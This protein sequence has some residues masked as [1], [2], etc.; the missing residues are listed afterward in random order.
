MS[1][2]SEGGR[3]KVARLSGLSE[4]T[5]E[6]DLR[7]FLININ[8]LDVYFPVNTPGNCYVEVESNEDL[9]K[10]RLKNNS[11][12][13]NKQIQC[14][15][16]TEA[17]EINN[18]FYFMRKNKPKTFYAVRLQRIPPQWT[19]INVRTFLSRFQTKEMILDCDPNRTAGEVYVRFATRECVSRVMQLSG[20][21]VG[22]R[23]LEVTHVNEQQFAEYGRQMKEIREAQRQPPP[24]Q[25]SRPSVQRASQSSQQLQQSF[26]NSQP[27]ILRQLFGQRPLPTVQHPQQSA[28]QPIQSTQRPQTTVQKPQQSLQH[29]Q[30]SVQPEKPSVQRFQPPVQRVQPIIQ[31]PQATT[32]EQ[33]PQPT[34]QQSPQ[35]IV[36]QPSQ[37]FQQECFHVYEPLNCEPSI[38]PVDMKNSQQNYTLKEDKFELEEK[39]EAKDETS[40]ED[41]L[42]EET[43]NNLPRLEYELMYDERHFSSK[44]ASIAYE[45]RRTAITRAHLGGYNN[46]EELDKELLQDVL[47]CGSRIAELMGYPSFEAMCLNAPEIVELFTWKRTRQEFNGR[48]FYKIENFTP[49]IPKAYKHLCELQKL[50]LENNNN[51]PTWKFV[52]RYRDKG[53][54]P[55]NQELAFRLRLCESLF[56]CDGMRNYIHLTSLQKKHEEIHGEKLNTDTYGRFTPFKTDVNL[57]RIMNERFHWEISARHNDTKNNLEFKLLHPPDF[58]RQCYASLKLARD[59]YQKEKER[60]G[61]DVESDDELGEYGTIRGRC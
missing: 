20:Q 12:L 6:N 19:E 25:Q 9:K 46:F 45:I 13:N 2:N 35:P 38:S 37:P 36:Q 48:V 27:T 58:L 32:V 47:V 60:A 17:H 50:R 49:I 57:Q 1:G 14:D 10:M 43:I 40:D 11:T 26:P 8:I 23:R 31:Q 51:D 3:G 15:V 42:D 33:P 29:S 16:I 34:V 24:T 55:T 4:Q 54:F 28:Q 22:V 21:H 30:P 59:D 52:L 7:M 39:E 53:E 61:A 41:E 44:M 5:T 56:Q 18:I